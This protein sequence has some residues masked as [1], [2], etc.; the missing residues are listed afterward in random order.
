MNE[1][2]VG[3]AVT[4][5]GI[6]KPG[7]VTEISEEGQLTVKY[8]DEGG[9]EATETGTADKFAPAEGGASQDESADDEQKE[10]ESSDES[11]DEEGSESAE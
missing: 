2:K 4:I 1:F 11:K 9:V 10:G 6:N 3:D 8:T 5:L 7:V